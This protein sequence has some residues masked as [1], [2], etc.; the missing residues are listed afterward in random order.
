TVQY[1][2]EI[3][4]SIQSY[5]PQLA[6]F[7]KKMQAGEH[8]MLLPGSYP[9][10]KEVREITDRILK[11]AYDKEIILIYA[12]NY[13]RNL[14]LLLFNDASKSRWNR[15][16]HI[17][18]DIAKMYQAKA[19]LEAD[20]VHAPEL[21][22]IAKSL[23]ISTSKLNKYF[24]KVFGQSPKEFWKERRIEKAADELKNSKKPVK[25]IVRELGY[26]QGTFF[27]AFKKKFSMTPFEWRNKW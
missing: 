18:P 22:I 13:A 9:F 17:S 2:E 20:L 1:Q 8:A 16:E 3:F 10:N 27:D 19:L 24:T 5:F 4:Y 6:A 14:L 12:G 26:K 23:A 25:Q 21:S 11:Y 7:T 15:Q